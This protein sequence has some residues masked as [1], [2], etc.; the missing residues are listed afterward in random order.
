METSL[1]ID[2]EK[3]PDHALVTAAKRGDT[4]ACLLYTSRCV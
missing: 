1:V 3:Y 4:H 2:L